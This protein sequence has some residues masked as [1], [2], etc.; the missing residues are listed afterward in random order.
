MAFPVKKNKFGYTNE[1]LDQGMEI[2]E[3]DNYCD[4]GITFSNPEAVSDN[5]VT[6][7]NNNEVTISSDN[8][9]TASDNVVNIYDNEVDYG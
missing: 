1:S 3:T 6:T 4:N 7:R 2:E 9:A 8:E 5:E